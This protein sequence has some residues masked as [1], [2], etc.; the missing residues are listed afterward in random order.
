MHISFPSIVLCLWPASLSPSLILLGRPLSPRFMMSYTLQS[1]VSPSP[2]CLFVFLRILLCWPTGSLPISPPPFLPS[3][4]RFVS[5]GGLL[6]FC[7]ALLDCPYFHLFTLSRC[8][9]KS[10]LVLSVRLLGFPPVPLI[11]FVLIIGLLYLF[12]I[13]PISLRLV[14]HKLFFPFSPIVGAQFVCCSEVV[15]VNV[16]G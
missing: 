11:L 4:P 3:L 6:I 12:A 16:H 8:L 1:N 9:C 7:F 10:S 14:S 2:R 5:G 15:S 13:V